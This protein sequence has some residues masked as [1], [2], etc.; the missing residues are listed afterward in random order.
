MSEKKKVDN[1]IENEKK[2]FK[3]AKEKN[4]VGLLLKDA[5]F[6]NIRSD[7]IDKRLLYG[8][9]LVITFLLV[10]IVYLQFKTVEQ[11][12]I[13]TLEAMREVELRS[14]IASVKKKIEEKEQKVLDINEKILE[15]LSELK[16]NSSAPE[17]LHKELE[18]AEKHLGLTAT[19]G[20]GIIITLADTDEVEIG[21][22]DI[23]MLIN[24]L[25]IAEAEAIS[26]NNERLI[27][28]S[29]VVT[30]NNNLIYVNGRRQNSPY[31]IKAI[32]N[33]QEL[34]AA[35]TTKGGTLNEMKASNKSVS[36]RLSNEVEIEA[37]DRNI[38]FKYV[39]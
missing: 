17:L 36:H 25:K 33:G 10:L 24:Q 4:F 13:Q 37:Y 2:S 34:E 16:N 8:I 14:E 22:T 39:R 30:V 1:K 28:S 31:V 7:I 20:A 18:Q 15:Y 19:K 27:F 38:D 6:K 9:V 23:L 21:S 5:K 35:I 12:D 29:E 32:G 3:K 26:I 11:T